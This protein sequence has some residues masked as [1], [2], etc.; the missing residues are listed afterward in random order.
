MR[1]TLFALLGL[2]A[3]GSWAVPAL[4]GD[5]LADLVGRLGVDAAILF[6][7]ILVVPEAM[8]YAGVAGLPPSA[9]ESGAAASVPCPVPESV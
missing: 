1:K 9:A 2:V 7:D 3:I 6:S 4:A 5:E 8:A